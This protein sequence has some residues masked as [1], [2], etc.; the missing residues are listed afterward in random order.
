MK[1]FVKSFKRDYIIVSA[2]LIILGLL[3][4]LLPEAAGMYI[5]YISG[6]VCCLMGVVRIIDYFRSGVSLRR[7]S[8]GLAFGL[9]LVS[10]G[11]FVLVRPQVLLE[12]IPTVF[13]IAIIFDSILKL[14]YSIDMLRLHALNWWLMLIIAAITGTLG[15]LM[16]LNPFAAASTLIIFG[17]AALISDGILDLVAL[18]WLSSHLKSIKKG[19]SEAE[20]RANA[21]DADGE[22]L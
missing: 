1:N 10:A 13:G 7:Y 15:A 5:C 11:V 9:I 21:I 3:L 19:L 17:G 20:K 4:V 22:L 8:T 2:T 14:Q 12:V 18:F 16:V 6:V